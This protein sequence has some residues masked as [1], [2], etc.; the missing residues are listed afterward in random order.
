MGKVI[1]WE[2]P[3][4]GSVKF[5]LARGAFGNVKTCFNG[6]YELCFDQPA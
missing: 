3:V 5:K 6:H 2:G 4:L 1:T